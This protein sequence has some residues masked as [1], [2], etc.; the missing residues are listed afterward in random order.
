VHDFGARLAARVDEKGGVVTTR[1]F[2][3]T[4]ELTA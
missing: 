4:K 2:I 1:V 3:P